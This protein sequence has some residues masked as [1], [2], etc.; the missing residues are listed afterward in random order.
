MRDDRVIVRVGIRDELVVSAG[1]KCIFRSR[2][3]GTGRRPRRQ[4]HEAWGCCGVD[5]EEHLLAG[6]RPHGQ[7]IINNI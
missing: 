5:R 6:F 2:A 7:V 3:I 1:K 4:R